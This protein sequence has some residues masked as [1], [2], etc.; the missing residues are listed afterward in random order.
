MGFLNA[1]ISLGLDRFATCRK[2]FRVVEEE[3]NRMN[4][5]VLERKERTRPSRRRMDRGRSFKEVENKMSGFR[6]ALSDLFQAPE[7]ELSLKQ[8]AFKSL[9]GSP[10]VRN[11]NVGKQKRN[12]CY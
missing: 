11:E 4:E 10:K 9:V 1:M 7:K 8:K 3:L 5:R 2:T 6:R 12:T